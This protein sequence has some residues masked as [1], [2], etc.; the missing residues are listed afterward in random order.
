MARHKKQHFVPRCY[1]KSWCDPNCPSEQTPYI[2]LFQRGELTGRKK[3]PENVFHSSDMYTLNMPDGSRD[4]TIEYS[5][6]GIEDRFTR[7]R[8]S[9]LSKHRDLSVEDHAWLNIFISA[10]HARTKK[11]IGRMSEQW[12]KPLD[13][14][15]QM[16]AAYEN[17]D[18]EKKKRMEKSP[19]LPLTEEQDKI[20]KEDIQA[21]VNDPV[22]LLMVPAIQAQAPLISELDLT[23]LCTE[24][25][26]GFITSD[27]PYIWFD[28]ESFKRPKMYQAPALMYDSIEIS[29]PISPRQ[30][31]LLNRR[32]RCG[33]RHVPVKAVEEI[34]RRTRFGAHEHYVSCSD[35]SNPYWFYVGER[36][37]IPGQAF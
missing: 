28:P 36:N 9:K 18:A 25:R 23:V 29:L 1:L 16:E 26:P 15:E 6:G 33:Y 7:I 21:M 5:F 11:S 31:I 32:G 10:M 19:S 34:N 3:S 27:H 8:N 24:S 35:K 12:Q 4:L 37:K 14:I 17:A 13:M 2:W 22:S 30:C 20:Y